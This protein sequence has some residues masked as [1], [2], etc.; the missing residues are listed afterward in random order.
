MRRLS[1]LLWLGL[2]ACAFAGEAA[3]QQMLTA[4]ARLIDAQGRE[5]GTVR[6][7]ETPIKGVLLRIEVSGLSAGDHAIH[8]HEV[9]RCDAPSFESAGGHFNPWGHAHGAAS[10]N[11]MHAGDL[12][13]LSVPGAGRIEL[14]RLARTVTLAEGL[15][16]SLFDEDGSSIVIHAGPD[17][18]VSQPSGNSGN[19]VV[20]GVIRR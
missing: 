19:A 20:C 8:I 14:E 7:Q 12:L 2:L 3:A 1:T 13:N 10:P 4:T 15:L 17:D 11:G 6:L 5:V 9:G 16:N 18:Y